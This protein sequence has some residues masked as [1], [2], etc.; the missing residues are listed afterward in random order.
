MLK[1]SG[2][3][4]DIDLDFA[5]NPVIRLKGSGDTAGMG[6]NNA[7]KI[8][9]VSVNG[10]SKEDAAAVN[11]GQKLVVTCGDVNEVMGSAQLS[12]CVLGK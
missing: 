8:T 7:G 9:D 10:L 12:D 1:V 2:T 5:D 4:K 6:I 11:K 3:V